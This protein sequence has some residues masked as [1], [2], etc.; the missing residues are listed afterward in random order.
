MATFAPNYTSRYLV[1]YR[2]AGRT[3]RMSVRY[4]LTLGPPPVG[5]VTTIS[6]VLT[7]LAPVLVSDFAVLSAGYIQQATAI[8]LPAPA[9]TAAGGTAAWTAGD[10]PRFISFTGRSITGQ[11][12][13]FYVYGVSL[14]PGTDAQVFANDYRVLVSEQGDVEIAVNE[15]NAPLVSI[16]ANDASEV[17]WNQYVNVAYNAYYQRKARR[18]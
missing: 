10:S 16:T 1:K 18:G 6:N 11:P 4:G 8:E 12:A 5:L 13:A 14:D 3:H 7:A 15:L 17:I 9:P 2:A